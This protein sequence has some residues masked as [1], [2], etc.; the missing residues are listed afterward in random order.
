MTEYLHPKPL[1]EDDGV[2]SVEI[3]RIPRW[4]ESELSGDEWRYTLSAI[5]TSK[6]WDKG[7]TTTERISG[8]DFAQM[9]LRVA[10]RLDELLSHGNQRNIPYTI[11]APSD[12]RICFQPGCARAPVNV[13]RIKQNWTH[14]PHQGIKMEGPGGG[15]F[16]RAF[17]K[18]HSHRGECDLE[19]NDDNY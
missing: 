7:G 9:T 11:K 3:K 19:D 6:D 17:C 8:N 2:V 10:N 14:F 15:S 12:L 1:P 13:Y 18:Q 4:K 16:V 5:I